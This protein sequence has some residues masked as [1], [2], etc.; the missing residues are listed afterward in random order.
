M[1][2]GNAGDIEHAEELINFAEAIVQRDAGTIEKT[3]NNLIKVA[4]DEVMIDTAG[5]ASN[6][7]R[8]VRIADSTGIIPGDLD[9]ATDSL[10]R[11]LG[12]DQFRN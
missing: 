2:G 6:F 10:Q 5:V 3:R 9:T 4:G 1:H 7:E 12:I 11:T 8:M